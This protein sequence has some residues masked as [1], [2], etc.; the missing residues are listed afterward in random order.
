MA[1]VLFSASSTMSLS[2][3]AIARFRFAFRPVGGSFASLMDRFRM[4]IG[5]VPAGSEVRK[6]RK[7]SCEPS[8]MN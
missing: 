7:S 6:T 8:P 4:P 2:K 5:M 3:L 1:R